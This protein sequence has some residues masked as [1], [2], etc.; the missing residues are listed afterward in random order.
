MREERESVIRRELERA[1][2]KK[3]K[4]TVSADDVMFCM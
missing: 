3:K 2:Y 1:V 4:N